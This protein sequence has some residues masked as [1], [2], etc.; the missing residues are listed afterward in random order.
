[1]IEGCKQ[2]HGVPRRCDSVERFVRFRVARMVA[3]L[4]NLESMYGTTDIPGY[5]GTFF[6]G[7]PTKATLDFY[8]ERS[9][10]QFV[11][12]V[13]PPLLILHGGNDQRQRALNCPTG[14]YVR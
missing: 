11:D 1:V 13:T 4:S 14:D 10:I 8:R 12:N 3:A 2:Q 5:V 7:I 6:S 9:A